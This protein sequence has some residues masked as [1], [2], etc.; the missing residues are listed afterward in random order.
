MVYAP[1]AF[2]SL[3]QKAAGISWQKIRR[4]L[5]GSAM[6]W[7]GDAD[8]PG[9]GKSAQARGAAVHLMAVYGEDYS[10]A[11]LPIFPPNTPHRGEPPIVYSCGINVGTKWFHHT[12]RA[13]LVLT[14]LWHSP[15][16]AITRLLLERR[17]LVKRI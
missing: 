16:L 7:R 9:F 12:S 15:A 13:L 4:R 5:V 10:A 3:V 1:R 2:F 14:G 6:P 8:I 11:S 17:G